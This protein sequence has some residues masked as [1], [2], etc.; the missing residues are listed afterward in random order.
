MSVNS[1][2]V[3][4]FLIQWIQTIVLSIFSPVL[5]V[6]RRKIGH[7]CCCVC[8]YVGLSGMALKPKSWKSLTVKSQGLKARRFGS[9]ASTPMAGCVP[10][11][12]YIAWCASR[13]L[14]VATVGIPH[15]VRC[16]CRLKSMTIST[17]T[18][19][20]LMCVPILIAPRVRVGSTLTKPILR[21]G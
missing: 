18:S 16:L 7:P 8:I 4:C 2:S 5:A 9:K 19:I 6:Q 10:K 12:A 20:P 21:C 3:G 15:L 13:H 11:L 17:S 1:N 14:T